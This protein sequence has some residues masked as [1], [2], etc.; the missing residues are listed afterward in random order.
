[1][2]IE[3]PKSIP[4]KTTESI[5]GA[6]FAELQKQ[7]RRTE[8]TRGRLVGIVGILT[9]L[10]AIVGYLRE[11][12]FAVRFGISS[13]T[14]AYFGAILIPNILYAV[15][16]TGTL[17]PVLVP[18]LLHKAKE[19]DSAEVSE[20]FNAVTTFIALLLLVTVGLGVV[21][22]RVWLPLLFAGFDRSTLE[23]TIHLVQMV[24]PGV[25]FLGLSGVLSATL[26][27]FH[28]FAMAA[29]APAVSSAII[30]ISVLVAPEKN[31]IY[32]VGFATALGFLL[33]CTVLV[34]SVA[35]LG[36]HFRPTLNL[37][38]PAIPKLLRLGVPLFLYLLVSNGAMFIE[39]HLASQISSGAVATLNYALRL[40]LVPANFLASPLATVAYPHF[41]REAF[42]EGRGELRA[43]VSK[44]LRL[45][46]FLFL[47]TTVWVILNALPVT[48]LL[49]QHGKFGLA[50][51]MLT[52]QVL[53]V[54]SLGILPYAIAMIVLRC[55][56]ALQD[57]AIPLWVELG[58]LAYYTV[59]A[60]VFSRHFG[61]LG[62]TFARS[63]EFM[64]VGFSLLLILRKR[65]GLGKPSAQTFSFLSRTVVASIVMGLALWAILHFVGWRLASVSTFVRLSFVLAQLVVGAGAYALMALLFKMQ[66]AQQALALLRDLLERAKA[67]VRG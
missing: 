2:P 30:I 28:K 3:S 14:D 13:T 20:T 12:A 42:R 43:E 6:D 45:V 36:I 51:S 52:S 35:K 59:A 1:L 55:L 38:H 10:V 9:V 25:V 46:V 47:P 49:Y 54:Y 33:Q 64:I 39:R 23:L 40:F 53:A 34:P 41:A 50:D 29:V 15:L 27:S 5:N 17:S 67:N 18:I 57:T 37:R 48:S 62:L 65:L 11:A 61:L 56:Y 19:D 24:L 21:T 26:N 4:S 16:V 60:I 8:P 31:A 63:S 58:A 7:K 22:C 66:E 44:T 32:V